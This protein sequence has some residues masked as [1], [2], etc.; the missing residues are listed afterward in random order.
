[1]SQFELYAAHQVN[2]AIVRPVVGIA[3]ANQVYVDLEYERLHHEWVALL[4]TS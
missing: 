1:V 2:R 4:S 3:D